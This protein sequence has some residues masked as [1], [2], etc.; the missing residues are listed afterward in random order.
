MHRS[1]KVNVTDPQIR[2]QKEA[3]R[4][5]IRKFHCHPAVRIFLLR[6]LGDSAI[7]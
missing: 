7:E 1:G 6:L 2:R 4:A 3:R 5:Q